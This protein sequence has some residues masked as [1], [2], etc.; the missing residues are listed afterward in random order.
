MYTIYSG[1]ALMIAIE[2]N[3]MRPCKFCAADG[4]KRQMLA[5]HMSTPVL[6]QNM[7]NRTAETALLPERRPVCMFATQKLSGA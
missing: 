5:L 4:T 2:Q 6:W 1:G 3:S 7:R